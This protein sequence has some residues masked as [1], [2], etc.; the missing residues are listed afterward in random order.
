MGGRGKYD[1]RG[2]SSVPVKLPIDEARECGR[3]VARVS[4]PA[5]RSSGADDAPA[6][7]DGSLVAKNS[8]IFQEETADLRSGGVW[9]A[10]KEKMQCRV[11]SALEYAGSTPPLNAPLRLRTAVAPLPP[12]G[13]GRAA[14]AWASRHGQSLWLSS[15]AP[16]LFI[17]AK[18]LHGHFPPALFGFC[19]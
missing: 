3:C 16:M 17:G 13:C 8:L 5:I 2:S 14:T 15:C 12:W 19:R 6:C 7:L 11:C 9:A 1:V 4:P 18:D 10:G